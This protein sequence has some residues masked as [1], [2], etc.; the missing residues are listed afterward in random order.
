MEYTK[1]VGGNWLTADD[2]KE[3]DQVKLVTESKMQDGKY[4]Y[5]DGNPKKENIVKARLKGA[6]ES[7]NFRLNWATINGLMDAFGPE[8]K[9]WVGKVLTVNLL[10]A[11]VGDTMR[12]IVYLIPEGFELKENAEK[13]VEIINKD[14]KTADLNAAPKEAGMDEEINPDDIPF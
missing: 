1:S 12:T 13:K 8:S 9:G 7:K 11:M 5:P 2:L 14:G 10:K 4:K 6:E 3:G